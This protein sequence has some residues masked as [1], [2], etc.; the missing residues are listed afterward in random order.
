M[1]RDAVTLYDS[2]YLIDTRA[3]LEQRTGAQH[4]TTST[5]LQTFTRCE[6]FDQYQPAMDIAARMRLWCA[7]N[8]LVVGAVIDHDSRT[9]T[10][11]VTIV[12]AATCG[13]RPDAFA[14]VSVDGGP[15]EV[16]A[17][18]TTDEGYWRDGTTIEI[19]CT[20]GLSWTWNGGAYLHTGDGAKQ[21][22]TKVFGL[23]VPVIGRCRDCTAVDDVAT[24]ATCRCL[25]VAI[26]CPDCGQRARVRLP[27]VPTVD[28]LLR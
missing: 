18:I 19:A 21:R 14:L 1:T 8:R 15:P 28:D 20:G 13:P 16:Y 23:G 17:D 11:P 4:V 2:Y 9:L 10:Q 12:L 26:Y 7:A 5:D 22:L 25:G 27:Q 6:V 3:W 24:E